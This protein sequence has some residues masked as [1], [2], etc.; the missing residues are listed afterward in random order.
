VSG[1]WSWLSIKTHVSKK[2]NT[3]SEESFL[4]SNKSSAYESV[5]GAFL[6]SI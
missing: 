6:Y 2:H 3:R 1:R 4:P 5:C